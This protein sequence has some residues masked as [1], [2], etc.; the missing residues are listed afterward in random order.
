MRNLRNWQLWL[1]VLVSSVVIGYG[2]V[3]LFRFLVDVIVDVVE[4]I[5]N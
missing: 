5:V 3:K 1:I 4:N 2:T